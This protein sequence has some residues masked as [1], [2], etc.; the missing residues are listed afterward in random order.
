M[1]IFN[2]AAQVAAAVFS[3]A[4][5]KK[6]QPLVMINAHQFFSYIDSFQACLLISRYRFHVNH[7]KTVYNRSAAVFKE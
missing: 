5:I 4:I 2:E 7:L 6:S 3:G 1:I